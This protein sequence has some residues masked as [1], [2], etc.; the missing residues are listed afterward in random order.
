[1]RQ[2]K[3]KIGPSGSAFFFVG[4][5]RRYTPLFTRRVGGERYIFL[6]IL[7]VGRDV[8]STPTKYR[9]VL[10][11]EIWGGDGRRYTNTLPCGALVTGRL[12]EL[13]YTLTE[14]HRGITTCQLSVVNQMRRYD[15]CPDE[16]RL[17][18][19]FSASYTST[20]IRFDG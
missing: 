20:N 3:T 6:I 16:R 19:R 5:C 7:A 15:I 17:D 2:Y 12:S 1:M 10:L 14:K 4:C 9:G 18:R 11:R 8:T 13:L